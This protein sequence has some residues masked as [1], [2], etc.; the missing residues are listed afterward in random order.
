MADG[1]VYLKNNSGSRANEDIPHYKQ[2][3]PK[4]LQK[5]R[6]GLIS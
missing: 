3:C 6:S 4:P 1:I 2:T 5:S